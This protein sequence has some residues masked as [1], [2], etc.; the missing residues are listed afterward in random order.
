M[1]RGLL[2][3][4][5][6]AGSVVGVGHAV[7][8]KGI[9]LEIYEGERPADAD[10]ILAPFFEEIDSQGLADTRGEARERIHETVSL[11][12]GGLTDQEKVELEASVNAAALKFSGGRFEEA[13]ALLL[14]QLERFR[15]NELVLAENQGFR[16]VLYRTL[17][18]LAAVSD[19]LG[20]T[21]EKEKYLTELAL[22]FPDQSFARREFG[23]DLNVAFDAIRQR[24]G[25]RG[26]SSLEIVTNDVNGI[27]LVNGRFVGVKRA[28][29]PDLL[30]GAYRIL[31]KSGTSTGRVHKVMLRPNVQE[32]VDVDLAFDAVLQSKTWVGLLYPNARAAVEKGRATATRLALSAGAHQVVVVGINKRGGERL[33]HATLYN[34]ENGRIVFRGSVGLGVGPELPPASQVRGLGEFIS[35]GRAIPGVTAEEG[36]YVAPPTRYRAW[37]WIAVSG[38]LAL[39]GA[40]IFTYTQDVPPI[41]P[42]STGTP[43]TPADPCDTRRT[44]R[45]TH[46]PGAI[47][48][49]VG[50]GLVIAGVVLFV[51]DKPIERAA[52]RPAVS[53]TPGKT[54]T[55]GLSGSF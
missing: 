52:V 32:V 8:Q 40:G 54:I 18:T 33:L 30:P 1:K 49:G 25:S 23:P 12:A 34:A 47:M 51:I 11:D 29:L 39:V 10:Q 5:V 6:L 50:A 46:V 24:M 42:N 43:C 20:K 35:T 31:V 7:A 55:F 9:T 41:I 45:R 13:E 36:G 21:A 2:V 19:R 15:A 44:Y 17:G 4:T 26:R 3:L 38:G 37:K 53:T 28:V 27:I 48:M 16:P 14:R 22:D